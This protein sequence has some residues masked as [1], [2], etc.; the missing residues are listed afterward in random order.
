MLKLVARRRATHWIGV[1]GCGDCLWI[2]VA[3]VVFGDAARHMEVRNDVMDWALA[4][5]ASKDRTV[6]ANFMALFQS[7]FGVT[8]VAAYVAR[9]RRPG[10]HSGQEEIQ[11]ASLR[12]GER[13]SERVYRVESLDPDG[14]LRYGGKGGGT[15]IFNVDGPITILHRTVRSADGKGQNEHG[16]H[17]DALASLPLPEGASVPHGRPSSRAQA[18]PCC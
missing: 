8:D 14:N 13:F 15:L 7:I 4:Q 1:D 3:I 11:L 5:A 18:R 10:E 12:Y 16:F 2:V 6:A 17:F 9:Q